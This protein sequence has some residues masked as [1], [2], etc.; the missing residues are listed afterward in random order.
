MSQQKIVILKGSPRKKGN[1]NIL[2]D[3]LAKGAKA[4]NAE[5]EEF[6][7]QN[8]DIKPCNACDACIRKPEK[9]CIIDDDMQLIYPKLRSA[10]SIVIASPI[11][12]FNMSAQTKILIDRFYG[13]IEPQKHALRKKRIGIILTYGDTNE[14]S[15][16]AINAINSFKDMFRY[17][18]AEIVGII[19]GSAMDAGQIRQ[20]SELMDKAYNIGVELASEA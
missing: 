14:H 19:H 18:G 7:L 20:N 5:V 12:W 16:G 17:I 13:L 11:Y 3:S 9:G 10:D 4:S 15:S 6:F 8:M 2:A 1:S